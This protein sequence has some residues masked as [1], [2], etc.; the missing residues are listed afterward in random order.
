MNYNTN[1]AQKLLE[2]RIDDGLRQSER[3]ELVCGNFLTPAEKAYAEIVVRSKRSS[4]RVFFFGGYS[5][6]ERTRI[7]FLPS[8]LSDLDGGAE[9]KARIYCADDFSVAICALKIKGS[10]YR[11]L[12]HRDYLGSILSLGIERREI[13][14]I[15]V[16]DEC[17]SIVFCTDRIR[18]YLLTSLDKIATDKVKVELFDLPDDFKVEKNTVRINDTVA[19]PRF[20][21]VVGALLNLSREKA[22]NLINS[23]LCEVDHLPELRVDRQIEAGAIIS[24]RGHGK[25]SVVSFDGE[26]RRGRIRMSAEKYV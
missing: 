20:D 13:G 25:F 7:F 14:D 12:S 10:G 18:D 24:V 3:G 19:S 15:V 1:D 22:Q 23:G 16:V 5:E 6:A 2:A 8:Y 26:T 11:A 9:E 17:E 21:C 4:D